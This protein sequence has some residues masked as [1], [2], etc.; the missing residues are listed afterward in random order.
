M[1]SCSVRQLPTTSP[2]YNY[3]HAKHVCMKVTS[4]VD[5]KRSLR[6][7]DKVVVRCKFESHVQLLST[8]NVH[9]VSYLQLPTRK[10]LVW[11]LNV[12]RI[13]KQIYTNVHIFSTAFGNFLI[14]KPMHF[15]YLYIFWHISFAPPSYLIDYLGP[16]HIILDVCLKIRTFNVNE[17]MFKLS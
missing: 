16:A 4:E 3:L 11:S 5:V 8:T 14:Q 15:T 7:Y 2:I 12:V 1:T 9:Y 17:N 13:N 6:R 10:A